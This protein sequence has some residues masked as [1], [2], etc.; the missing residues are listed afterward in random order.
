MGCFELPWRPEPGDRF[1]SSPY[2]LPCCSPNGGKSKGIPC[3]SHFVAVGCM[4]A[5]KIFFLASNRILSQSLVV[6]SICNSCWQSSQVGWWENIRSSTNPV[7]HWGSSEKGGVVS[8]PV[9][10][11]SRGKWPILKGLK[12]GRVDQSPPRLCTLRLHVP[13]AIHLLPPQGVHGSSRSWG[14]G[15][16]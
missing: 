4:L 7:R 14:W 13:I 5:P 1:W 3:R 11:T 2:L 16:G 8:F 15:C 12:F 6:K 9:I 10:K